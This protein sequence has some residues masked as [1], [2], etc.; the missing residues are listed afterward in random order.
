MS[1]P[2]S[3]LLT[4]LHT[5]N[6]G[7]LDCNEMIFQAL[8]QLYGKIGKKL[9]GEKVLQFNYSNRKGWFFKTVI[10]LPELPASIFFA[11]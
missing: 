9:K 4:Q 1:L 2:Y 6:V 5:Y 10:Q 11:F 7:L 8:E 3:E